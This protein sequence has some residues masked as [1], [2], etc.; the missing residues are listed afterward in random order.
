MSEQDFVQINA[1]SI[2]SLIAHAV[3]GMDTEWSVTEHE[4]EFE[5]YYQKRLKKSGFHL[6][7]KLEACLGL[8]LTERYRATGDHENAQ[9]KLSLTAENFPSLKAVRETATNYDPNM[10]INWIKIIYPKT[11]IAPPE[12]NLECIGL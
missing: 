1:P 10:A 5:N 11:I 8:A 12:S 3:L 6:P 2:E 9:K 7:H 4:K